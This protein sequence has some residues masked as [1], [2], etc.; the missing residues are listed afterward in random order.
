MTKI[1]IFKRKYSPCY[2]FYA[3]LFQFSR[4]M[5]LN[6]EWQLWV[7]LFSCRWFWAI[8]VESCW[9]MVCRKSDF[10]SSSVKLAEPGSASC[11]SEQRRSRR[12]FS[13]G[14]RKTSFVA[15]L[16][17]DLHFLWMTRLWDVVSFDIV[18]EEALWDIFLTLLGL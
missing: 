15:I 2:F 6:D 8:L 9:A 7:E 14:S 11:L 12:I 18:G 17:A 4:Y 13:F 3:L 5:V 1:Q 16:I 10:F